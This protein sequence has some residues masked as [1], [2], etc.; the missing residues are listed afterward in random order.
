MT[1]II[2]KYYP[3]I[4]DDI[5]GNNDIINLFKNLSF[6]NIPNILLSGDYG[7]GKTTILNILLKNIKSQNNILENNTDIRFINLDEDLKKKNIHTFLNFLKKSNQKIVIIDNYQEISLDY[8]YLLRSIVKK[9]NNNTSFLFF[10]NNSNR[11]IE[12][13]SCFFL[14]LKL[15]KNS[16]L[17]YF[18]FLK[19]IINKENLDISDN[20]LNHIVLISNNFREIIN[21]FTILLNF[22]LSDNNINQNELENILNISDKKYAFQ[23]FLL[24]DKNDIFNAIKLIHKLLNNGYSIFDIIQIFT[25]YIK[26]FENIEY[27]K[28][29]KYIELISFTHIKN[30]YSYNQLC[31]LI[32]KMCQV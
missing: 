19:N 4:L 9:Y 7:S 23:I 15:E 25:T 22:Y 2:K 8:Q 20:I 1:T 11:I 10:L 16:Q 30:H 3:K 28:K 18:N 29:I 31:S 32:S 13:L 27:E 17:E 14:I 21:N 12:Q 5:I 6:N 24:C 26:F